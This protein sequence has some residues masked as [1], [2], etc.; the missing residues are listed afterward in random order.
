MTLEKKQYIRTVEFTL[1]DGEVN[2][3]CHI[4][5]NIEIVEDGKKISSSN[6]RE[7]ISSRKAIEMLGKMEDY[8]HPE[9]M[10]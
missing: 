6:H 7:V 9:D 3:S 10:R 8:R 2:P 5:Y 1:T 4:E